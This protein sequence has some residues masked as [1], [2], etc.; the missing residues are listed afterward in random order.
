M[1]KNIILFITVAMIMSVGTISVSGAPPFDIKAPKGITYEATGV[2]TYI[3]DTDL[4]TPKVFPPSAVPTRDHT[5]NEFPLGR[6]DITW[7]VGNGAV[8]DIQT[9]IVKDTIAPTITIVGPS[10]VTIAVGDKYT[11]EGATATDIVDGNVTAEIQSTGANSVDTSVAGTYTVTYDVS[12]SSGNKAEQKIRTVYVVTPTPT[13]VVTPTPTAIPVDTIPPTI[14]EHN[15]SWS[16]NI[17]DP[18]AIEFNIT[19][20]QEVNA[21]WSIDGVHATSNDSYY[22][23]NASYVGIINTI[24]NHTITVYI[25]N[26]NGSYNGSW[27]LNVNGGLEISANPSSVIV[28]QPTNVTLTVTRKCGIENEDNLTNCTTQPYV[29]FSGADVHIAEV[30]GNDIGS[31]TTDI[32]GQ[33]VTLVNATNVGT[34]LATASYPPRYSSGSANI[35]ANAAPSPISGGG[36]NGGNNN[37]GGSS[38]GGSSGGSSGGGGGGGLGTAEPYENVLK[39]EVQER[40]VFTT[41]VL[42]QYSTSELAIYDVLITSMQSNIAALR[43]EVL[44]NTS[45]L[46]D[47]PVSGVVYKNINA[48]MDYKRIKNATIRYKVENS[49]ISGNGLLDNNVKMS[50]WDDSNKGWTELSTTV[51]NKDEIYTYFESQ[52]DNMSGSFA[53][54]GEK[55]IVAQDASNDQYIDTT[56]G[57]TG[58]TPG[59]TGTV[60]DNQTVPTSSKFPKVETVLSFIVVGSVVYLYRNRN[61]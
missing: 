17:T 48:W 9:V 7:A 33:I 56:P 11:D 27:N 13:P 45:K 47:K 12:D 41:P 30:V 26:G 1:T 3:S 38:G 8:T 24:G 57:E 29:P 51:A 43:I 31:G 46:V 34:V 25:E 22:V 44:R 37:G 60:S 52:V 42:F 39:Y 49:W 32:N 6:T 53:I 4:G 23:A 14:V 10:V 36:N 59:E 20:D 28:G 19:T 50:K 2:M 55:D 58:T 16:L 35:V 15:P 21:T 5:D 40:N 54:N 61:K 18:S